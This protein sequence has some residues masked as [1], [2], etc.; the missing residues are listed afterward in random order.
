MAGQKE[1]PAVVFIAGL[2]AYDS[3]RVGLGVCVL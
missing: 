3:S 2:T 1:H